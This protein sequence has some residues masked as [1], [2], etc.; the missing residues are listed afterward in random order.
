LHVHD[1]RERGLREEADPEAPATVAVVRYRCVACRAV[2]RVLPWFL[3][4]LLWR[5]WPVVEAATL[6]PPPPATAPRV[7]VRTV[8]R[9]C[10]RLATAALLLVEVLRGAG[11]ALPADVAATAPRRQLVAAYAAAHAVPAGA[12]LAL[13]A[14]IVHRLAPGVRLM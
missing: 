5:S 7:P 1:Y 9:W 12:R 3:A 11:G 13:L 14:V 8:Q 4:R 6:G 2:W 10:A